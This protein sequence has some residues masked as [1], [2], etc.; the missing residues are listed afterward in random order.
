V[1]AITVETVFGF[2][3]QSNTYK[4]VHRA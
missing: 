1:L 2:G 3:Y 4:P